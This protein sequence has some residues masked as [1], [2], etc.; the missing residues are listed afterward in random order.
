MEEADEDTKD[1]ILS[2]Y[3]KK[4]IWNDDD[5]ETVTHKEEQTSGEKTMSETQKTLSYPCVAR[6]NTD[7]RDF[8]VVRGI[9][10]WTKGN[11]DCKI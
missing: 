8:K 6:K 9:R 1:E 4:K 5:D 2:F 3:P 7:T 11:Q 10:G